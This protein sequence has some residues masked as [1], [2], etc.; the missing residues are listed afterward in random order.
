MEE[1]VYYAHNFVRKDARGSFVE[2]VDSAL[3]IGKMM[4]NFCKYNGLTNKMEYTIP[5]YLNVDEALY[6]I[7]SVKSTNLYRKLAVIKKQGLQTP[8]YSKLSG[9][10][11]SKLEKY[12]AKLP[13]EVPAGKTVS[14]T[15][16]IE[17]SSKY[18]Y[19]LR[20][21]YKLGREDDK[22]LIIP[23][24]KPLAYIMVALSHEDLCGF[25][26]FIEKRI[27]AYETAKMIAYASEYDF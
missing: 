6:L 14:K 25:M 17:P 5:I 13:F 2:A 12:K 15:F 22:G 18:D 16:T 4:L 27:Q 26:L 10:S 20:A 3:P 19:L 11:M 7:E 1:K 21:T 8:A 23:E 24:G 9:I